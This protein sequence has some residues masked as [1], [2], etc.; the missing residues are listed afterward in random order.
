MS[1]I[2]ARSTGPP[3][4]YDTF[5]APPTATRSASPT[6][7]VACGLHGSR[8]DSIGASPA[9]HSTAEQP[10]NAIVRSSNRRHHSTPRVVKTGTR[11]TAQMTMPIPTAAQAAAGNGMLRVRA[12]AACASMSTASQP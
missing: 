6:S 4:T 1:R 5:V 7:I 12:W 9:Y 11:A 10:R 8:A 2:A 3:A